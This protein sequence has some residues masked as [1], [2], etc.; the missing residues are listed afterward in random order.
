MLT[1]YG[2]ILL[3]CWFHSTSFS[4]H[5]IYEELCQIKACNHFLKGIEMRKSIRCPG[6]KYYIR[7]VTNLN[8]DKAVYDAK[9]EKNGNKVKV[10]KK[11][12]DFAECKWMQGDFDIGYNVGFPQD[13]LKQDIMHE[14]LC[15]ALISQCQVSVLIKIFLKNGGGERPKN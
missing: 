10:A 6:V 3:C 9:C 14:K 12:D 15:A 2:S 1:E 11:D 8:L 4:F 5:S 7:Y 13:K